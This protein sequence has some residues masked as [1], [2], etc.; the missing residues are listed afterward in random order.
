METDECLRKLTLSGEIR[1]HI[2]RDNENVINENI[3][4]ATY[5]TCSAV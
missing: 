5:V 2:L 3:L 1:Q 4:K